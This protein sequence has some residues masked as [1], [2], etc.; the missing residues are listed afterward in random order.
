L[1]Q[2]AGYYGNIVVIVDINNPAEPRHAGRPDYIIATKRLEQVVAVI[3]TSSMSGTRV[4]P[5]R[6]HASSFL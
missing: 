2:L 5:W 3:C 1:H 4:I 6:S